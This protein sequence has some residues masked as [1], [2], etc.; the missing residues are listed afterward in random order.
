MSL[1]PLGF[2]AASGGGEVSAYELI[3]TSTTSATSLT[4]SSIPADFMHLQIRA[5]VRTS[6]DLDFGMRINGDTSSS[7][8][9]HNLLTTGST[10][11]SNASTGSNRMFLGQSQ[12]AGDAYVYSPYLID[13]LDYQNTNKNTTVRYISSRHS[14]GNSLYFGSGL[15]INTSA[16]TSITF[17]P[18][19]GSFQSAKF[20][21]YGI[22]GA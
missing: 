1:I 3:E 12:G 17:L 11:S 10:P 16:V 2:W 22:R 19:S 13:V 20:S 6:G 7:Y 8:A 18:N 15:W 21:L 5:T 14:G 4:F 9:V